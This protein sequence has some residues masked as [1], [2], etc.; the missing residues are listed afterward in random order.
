MLA[1]LYR[2]D[3]HLTPYIVNLDRPPILEPL[4]RFAE[5]SIPMCLLCDLLVAASV[6]PATIDVVFCFLFR[7]PFSMPV[8]NHSWTIS[9]AHSDASIA[10][11][12]MIGFIFCNI[13]A[14]IEIRL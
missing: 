4:A 9:F 2:N 8:S 5:R 12:N 13:V 3:V 7:C 10:S 1:Q 11:D 6:S 14:H